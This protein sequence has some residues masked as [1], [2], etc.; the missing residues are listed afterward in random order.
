[1]PQDI[2]MKLPPGPSAW[3]NIAAHF[4]ACILDGIECQAPLRHGLMVQQML[5]GLLRSA[6]TGREVRLVRRQ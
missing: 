3:D 2:G 1:V 5:E 4:I 6:E